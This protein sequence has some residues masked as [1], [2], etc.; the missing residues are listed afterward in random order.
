MGFRGFKGLVG[1]KGCNLIY[2]IFKI[3]II[4]I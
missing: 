4:K 2:N 3:K 1:D